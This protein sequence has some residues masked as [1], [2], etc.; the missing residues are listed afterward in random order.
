M[1]DLNSHPST[2]IW[3]ISSIDKWQ[4]CKLGFDASVREEGPGQELFVRRHSGDKCRMRVELFFDKGK[5]VCANVRD[6]SLY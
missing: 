2:S 6:L 5:I 1:G 3:Q 4:G